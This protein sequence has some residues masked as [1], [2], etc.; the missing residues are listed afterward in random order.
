MI[1]RRLFRCRLIDK[2]TI[3]MVIPIIKLPTS[4]KAPDTYPSLPSP[5]TRKPRL[6]V[7]RKKSVL[8]VSTVSP[9]SV[10]RSVLNGLVRVEVLVTKKVQVGFHHQGRSLLGSPGG[11][12]SELAV[13]LNDF[14]EPTFI[15]IF[16]SHVNLLGFE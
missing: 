16:V 6:R 12:F 1:S 10:G 2:R 15:P 8:I 4:T 11:S 3:R 5:L 14:Q 13:F 7:N 9:L